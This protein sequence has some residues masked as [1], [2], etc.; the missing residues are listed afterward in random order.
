MV[1][2]WINYLQR[3]A[4]AYAKGRYSIRPVRLANAPTELRELGVALG[5]MLETI[6]ARNS[7]LKEL[8][9]TGP[10]EPSWP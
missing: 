10:D 8:V 2:Q 7:E 3:L 9:V 1:I 4:H 6:E 5:E